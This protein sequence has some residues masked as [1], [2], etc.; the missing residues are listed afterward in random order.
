ML[1]QL[2]LPLVEIALPLL[3]LGLH[4]ALPHATVMLPLQDRVRLILLELV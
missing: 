1:N 3:Q 2:I 4:H